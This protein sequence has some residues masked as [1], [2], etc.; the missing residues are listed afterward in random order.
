MAEAW[1]GGN[2]SIMGFTASGAIGNYPAAA[3][4]TAVSF[5]HNGAYSGTMGAVF[6]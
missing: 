4:A 1:D 3:P 6:R 5:V 2:S